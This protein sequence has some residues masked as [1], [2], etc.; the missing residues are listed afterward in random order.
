MLSKPLSN[1]PNTTIAS[2]LEKINSYLFFGFLQK[3]P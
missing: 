3:S 1:I 2:G